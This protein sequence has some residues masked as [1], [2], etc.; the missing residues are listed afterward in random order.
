MNDGLNPIKHVYG[1]E[2]AGTPPVPG[3]PEY[4]EFEALRT[5][6]EALDG[7][8]Q[9]LP[10]ANSVDAIKDAA[11]AETLLPLRHV[12]GEEVAALNPDDARFAEYELLRTTKSAL[13][14]LPRVSADASVLDAVKMAASA[15][16]LVPLQAAYGETEAPGTDS[17]Q[18][19]EYVL[20]DSMRAAL[21]QLPS[22]RPDASVVA[23]VL[24]AAKP[25]APAMKVA[26]DRPAR[27]AS[28]VRRWT[29]AL[30]MAASLVVVAVTGLWVVETFQPGEQADS[31]LV[32]DAQH[33]PSDEANA[34][35]TPA[36]PDEAQEEASEADFSGSV[37]GSGQPTVSRDRL[38]GLVAERS[39]SAVGRT[40]S[41]GARLERRSAAQTPPPPPAPAREVDGLAE[42]EVLMADV[43]SGFDDADTNK[44]VPAVSEW[45]EREDVRV[46]SLRLNQLANSSEGLSWDEPPTPLGAAGPATSGAMEGIRP[47]RSGPA[48]GRVDVQ[49]R[50]SEQRDD[51]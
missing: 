47:V 42:S 48:T 11:V 13:D 29:P 28:I 33:S 9:P 18:H 20:L 14:T 17:E 19:A 40:Q 4:A 45:E 15:Q 49:M 41:A 23:A 6:K 36:E 46:L 22:S 1:E 2:P 16:V 39:T 21:G 10:T 5:M 8:P 35:T 38:D 34:F 51:Q 26:S 7:L 3:T 43:A 12:Y 44:P 27:S 30:A 24:A 31:Q 25:G 50:S 32:A 37:A